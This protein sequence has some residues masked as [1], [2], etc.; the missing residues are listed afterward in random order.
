MYQTQ[1]ASSK[2]RGHELPMYTKEEL[3]TWLLQQPHFDTLYNDWEKSNFDKWLK[4]SI[5]RL[6]DYKPYTL[7][8]IQLMTWQE[9]C[10]KSKLDRK[11]GRN[12]KINR[13]VY[14]FTIDGEFIKE[15]HSTREVR[16]L[17]KAEIKQRN[18]K[19]GIQYSKGYKWTFNKEDILNM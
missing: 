5:D 16:R 19:N 3:Q 6:D 12:N 14:Q 9:N 11:E 8:N 1:K 4:P 13:T 15:H 2:K 10:E 17:F 7:D 18:M